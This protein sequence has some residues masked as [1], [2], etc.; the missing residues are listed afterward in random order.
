M[1]RRLDELADS[2]NAED[3]VVLE[4]APLSPI[5]TSWRFCTGRTSAQ[6][7]GIGRRGQ[8]KRIKARVGLMPGG[9]EAAAKPVESRLS[10]TV[11]ARLH[12]PR[13]AIRVHK[14]E[15]SVA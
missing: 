9:V 2:K 8:G 14:L 10:R 6:A 13:R 11:S 12:R 5:R 1:A 3:I 4:I 7:R 15:D